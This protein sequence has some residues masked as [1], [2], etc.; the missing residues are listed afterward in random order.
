MGSSF[1]AHIVERK[2]EPFQNK[3]EDEKVFRIRVC[4]E[5]EYSF[6]YI[7]NPKW[8][9]DLNSPY[10][11]WI[12][13]EFCWF[14]IKSYGRSEPETET[15]PL[16]SSSSLFPRL[17]STPHCCVQLSSSAQLVEHGEKV[18]VSWDRHPESIV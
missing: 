16:P 18:A 17:V 11:I 10:R 3:C 5:F 2:K 14:F 15:I 7:R 13:R 6:K 1:L 4:L 8:L 12:R 9:S